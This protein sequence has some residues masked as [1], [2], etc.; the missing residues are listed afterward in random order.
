M[1]RASKITKHLKKHNHK[2]QV[3]S[4]WG[5]FIFN[6]KAKG[7]SLILS[8]TKKENGNTFTLWVNQKL[9]EV[10]LRNENSIDLHLS[11]CPDITY[12]VKLINHYIKQLQLVE[13]ED[14]ICTDGNLYSVYNFTQY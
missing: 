13:V 9:S 11:N 7:H 12:I 1:I 8:T 3:G 6:N 10:N 2:L 14:T 4:T 5:V